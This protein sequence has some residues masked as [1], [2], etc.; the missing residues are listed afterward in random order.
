IV[1]IVD[2]DELTAGALLRGVVDEILFGAVRADVAFEREFAGDDLFDGDFFVP[3]VA[4]VLL[5]PSRLRHLF[6][7]AERAPRFGDRL[8]WH[9]DLIVSDRP[10]CPSRPPAPPSTLRRD[11]GP[12]FERGRV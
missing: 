9:D 5:F 1:A 3:A 6:G 12:L 2:N 11:A 10:P 7:A 4:A 8:A